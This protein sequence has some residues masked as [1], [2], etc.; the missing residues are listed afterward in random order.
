MRNLLLQIISAIAGIWIAGKI[1]PGVD[2]I[3]SFAVLLLAGAILGAL[4]FF[5]KPLLKTISW[6]LRIITLN[7]FTFLIN[8][9]LVWL[10]TIAFP[11][12]S[13][14]GIIALFWTT[15]IIWALGLILTKW[16]GKKS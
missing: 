15:L 3:G 13:A 9:L 7:L 14:K 5:V 12:V 2:F 1:A 16:L 4:N 10:V 6:P 8:M 11:E